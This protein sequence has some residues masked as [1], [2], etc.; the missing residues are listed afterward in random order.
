MPPALQKTGNA[1]SIFDL[2]ATP[3][4]C[5]ARTL[6]KILWRY[7]SVI[8]YLITTLGWDGLRQNT[9][10]CGPAPTLHPVRVAWLHILIISYWIFEHYKINSA[11][12][13]HPAKKN[14]VFSRVL[15]EILNMIVCPK[16]HNNKHMSL[17]K[18]WFLSTLVTVRT[19]TSGAT[20][21]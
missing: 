5:G 16:N 2:W 21:R 17:P 14:W 15:R 6:S 11:Q 12:C 13:A 20:A 4:V 10:V 8:C 3:S 1:A 7:K 18:T 19:G 9:A